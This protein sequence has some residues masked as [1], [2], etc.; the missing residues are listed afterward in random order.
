MKYRAIFVIIFV[1]LSFNLIAQ[2]DSDDSGYYKNEVG[3]DIS[4][5]ITVLSKKPESYL[6]NYKRYLN[7]N[8]AIRCGLDIEWSTSDDGYKGLKNKVGYEWDRAIGNW[9]WQF[10]YGADV[11]F[12]YRANNFQPNKTV[13]GGIHPLIGFTHYFVK[14]FSLA[15]ELNLNFFCSRRIKPGSF[16]PS[17]NKTVFE[18]SVGSVGMLLICYH[19]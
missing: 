4:N 15:T 12:L 7:K 1:F 9:K 8:K 11:S 3:I 13:R 6:L 2:S 16:D 18:V 14:Q 19:F 5:V 10:F 17:D